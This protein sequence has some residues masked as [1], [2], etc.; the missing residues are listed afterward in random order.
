M[1]SHR[2]VFVCNTVDD[3]GYNL[4]VEISE[5]F[6]DSF[7]RPLR[8][9]SDRF[10][11]RVGAIG[12]K[13]VRG[14]IAIPGVER[15]EIGPYYVNVHKGV[16]FDWKEIHGHVVEVLRSAFPQGNVADVEVTERPSVEPKDPPKIVL[17]SGEPATAE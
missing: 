9:T 6:H 7:L 14:L 10:L 3:R 16:A 4:T 1:A 5:A 13:V 11:E 12:E 2:I 17:P 15:V 8:D